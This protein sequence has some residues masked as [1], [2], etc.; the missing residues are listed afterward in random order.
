MRFDLDVIETVAEGSIGYLVGT[1]VADM[2]GKS[3]K[4]VTHEAYRLMPDGTWKCVV[5]MWHDTDL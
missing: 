1:Y 5:D 2:A 4:G 3:V